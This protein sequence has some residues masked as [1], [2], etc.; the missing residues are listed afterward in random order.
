MIAPYEHC[1]TALLLLLLLVLPQVLF[2]ASDI[3]G[4]TV[5]M[6]IPFISAIAVFILPIETRGRKLKV[7]HA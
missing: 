2:P 3:A 5:F 1:T 4:I 7:S 6:V